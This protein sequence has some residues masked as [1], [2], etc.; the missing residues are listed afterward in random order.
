M[1][2]IILQSNSPNTNQLN[3][4]KFYLKDIYIMYKNKKKYQCP[5]VTDRACNMSKPCN[6]CM[7]FFPKLFEKNSCLKCVRDS[8]MSRSYVD[9]CDQQ[10][11]SNNI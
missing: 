1:K 9:Q 4:I 10:L 7:H 5:Y 11:L 8:C 3:N 2:Q 6:T